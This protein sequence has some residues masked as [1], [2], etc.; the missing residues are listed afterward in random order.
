MRDITAGADNSPAAAVAGEQAPAPMSSATGG[1]CCC[2]LCGYT[3]EEGQRVVRSPEC[4]EG[5]MVH[6]A[7]FESEDSTPVFSDD[8]DGGALKFGC[9]CGQFHPGV[10]LTAGVYALS[11]AASDALA[12][13][14]TLSGAGTPGA[15]AKGWVGGDAGAMVS[16][17]HGLREQAR[18]A[19]LE[20]C[21]TFVQADPQALAVVDG[22]VRLR[23][24]NT[25][26]M[27]P[28]MLPHGLSPDGL[29]ERFSRQD[30]LSREEAEQLLRQGTEILD[31]EDNVL[32]LEGE[33]VVVGDLHGQFFDLLTLLKTYGEP[34]ERQYLF[35]G[36]YVDRGLYSCEVALYLVSLKLAFPREVHLI[37]GNHET[38]NQ[39]ATCGF[40]DECSAKYG[41]RIYDAFLECFS[42]L[43]VCA[44]LSQKGQLESLFCVHGG[45]SPRLK[46]VNDIRR[47]ERRVEPEEGTLLADLLWSDPSDDPSLTVSVW[48]RVA[49]STFHPWRSPR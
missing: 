6:Q 9:D 35:L 22:E 1:D 19:A 33:T 29:A 4:A 16:P 40:K 17:R 12:P 49:P 11:L 2:C 31:K 13:W 39:T 38:A 47:L 8:S 42:A 44:I 43:P 10:G 28:T 37:R 46:T 21:P 27:T 3:I 32:E 23:P 45:I 15:G 14:E 7:C 5:L 18:E 26:A 20:A 24:V 41:S 30:V 25:P 34:P 48:A 36:D